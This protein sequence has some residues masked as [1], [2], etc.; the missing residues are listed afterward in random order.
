M[1]ERFE[2][3]ATLKNASSASAQLKKNA[4]RHC[5]Q[6]R[7]LQTYKHFQDESQSTFDFWNGGVADPNGC[8]RLDHINLEIGHKDLE[9]KW[10]H[11]LHG[12][13][14]EVLWSKPGENITDCHHQVCHEL[15]GCC[16]KTSQI[17][18]ACQYVR[19]MNNSLSEGFWV[20]PSMC[21]FEPHIVIG[22]M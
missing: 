10:D 7:A 15:Y 1:L 3:K 20:D 22:D 5:S 6:S 13:V 12:P 16:C 17:K 19:A 14:G 11:A 2:P 21:L 4:L 18:L 9:Q 8:L